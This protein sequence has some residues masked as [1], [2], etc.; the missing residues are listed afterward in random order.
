VITIPP[1][2]ASLLA[3]DVDLSSR[4]DRITTKPA[5]KPWASDRTPG[6][7]AE[8][9]VS[10]AERSLDDRDPERSAVTERER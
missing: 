9:R 7:F 1:R 3:V 10:V 2:S 8:L 4:C 5:P 6:G